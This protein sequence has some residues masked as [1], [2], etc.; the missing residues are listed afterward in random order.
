MITTYTPP[1]STDM[2]SFSSLRDEYSFL[3]SMSR[4][5]GYILLHFFIS[6]NSSHSSSRVRRNF[7]L[8]P[9]R[10][11]HLDKHLIHVIKFPALLLGVCLSID[12]DMSYYIP[13]LCYLFLFF[14]FFISVS[15]IISAMIC[16][17]AHSFRLFRLE[18]KLAFCSKILLQVCMSMEC[19]EDMML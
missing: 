16:M 13:V 15:Y 12:I 14:F 8:I 9:V 1:E 3:S 4:V 11:S 17:L 7:V 10:L 2:H 5:V 6:S 19:V 18:Y